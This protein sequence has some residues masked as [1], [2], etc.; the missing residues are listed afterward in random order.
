MW[1]FFKQLLKQNYS[2]VILVLGTFFAGISCITVGQ[3]DT[4]L[5][6]HSP[7]PL[8]LFV[9]G[10]VLILVSIVAFAHSV[11]RPA[12][13]GGLDL[14]VVKENRGTFSITIDSCEIRVVKGKLEDYTHRVGSVVVLPCNEYFD[15]ECATDTKSALGAYVNNVFRNRCAE[16]MSL[17]REECPRVF[18]DGVEREKIMAVSAV[19]FGVGVCLL[20]EKPLDHHVPVALLST[21]TQSPQVGL[22]SSVSYLF[23]G[24]K[25]LF[26]CM[27][28]ARF[29]RLNEVV[30][31]LLGSGHGGVDRPL[32]FVG[33]LIAIAEAV[34]HGHGGFRKRTVT[35]VIYKRDKSTPAE[36]DDIVIRRGLALIGS[37]QASV[38]KVVPV[39]RREAA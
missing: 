5:L 8:E 24:M 10:V 17:V 39:R 15:D 11:W 34:R 12:D 28:D 30:M 32:A 19:S 22:G 13:F 7:T 2:V 3:K 6:T 1:S 27:A 18:G 26:K 31:P 33:L 21:T 14:S 29:A 37:K 20:L 4:Y 38:A 16:F 23:E 9:L 36:V 35:I 25:N